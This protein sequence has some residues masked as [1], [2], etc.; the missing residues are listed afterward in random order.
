M[1][2]WPWTKLR[3]SPRVARTG[4]PS[5]ALRAVPLPSKS[6]G[7]SL[8]TQHLHRIRA[9]RFVGRVERGEERE[10][11]RRQHDRREF[12]RVGLRRE[13]RQEPHRRIPQVLTGDRL[14]GIDHILAEVEKDRRDDDS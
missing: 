14:N 6:R 11:Q 12:D 10:D 8:I 2:T 5:T 9:R 4:G 1:V 3:L 7:G 13:L